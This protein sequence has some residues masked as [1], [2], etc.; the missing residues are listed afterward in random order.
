MFFKK[1]KFLK[2][3]FIICIM[4]TI[5]GVA[6]N[7]SGMLDD[8]MRPPI[9][10]VPISASPPGSIDVNFHVNREDGFD[11]LVVFN[12]DK[13]LSENE[14]TEILFGPRGYVPISWKIYSLSGEFIKQGEGKGTRGSR[15]ARGGV[16]GGRGQSF[17]YPVRLSPGD[18][19]LVLRIMEDALAYKDVSTEIQIKH[20]TGFCETLSWYWFCT[21]SCLLLFDIVLGVIIFLK[22]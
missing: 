3:I 7:S 13:S 22:S 1:N 12:R 5:L 19:R 9:T 11:M 16:Y 20:S 21:I 18:Y 10:G 14:L 2:F 4:L 8:I 17:D 15:G 6:F